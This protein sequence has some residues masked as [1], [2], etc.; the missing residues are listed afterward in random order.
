MHAAFLISAEAA[1]IIMSPR[2][3]TADRAPASVMHR[4]GKAGASALGATKNY[5]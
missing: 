1:T 4:I 2:C 3:R 5:R